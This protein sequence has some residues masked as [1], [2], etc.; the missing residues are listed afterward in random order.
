M[1]KKIRIAILYDM[2]KGLLT[3]KESDV[4]DLYYNEDLS[5][6]EIAD[7]LGITRQAVRDSIVRSEKILT[8]TEE[9]T[10]LCE[11]IR[12]LESRLSEINK[13][14]LEQPMNVLDRIFKLSENGEKDGI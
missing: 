14:V 12:N 1:D 7:N 5:L 4:I 6:S 9:K 13:L 2:Y 8:E 10:G 11:R 3:K